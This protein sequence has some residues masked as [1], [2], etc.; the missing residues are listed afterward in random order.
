MI[1]PHNTILIA[2][3]NAAII[4][5]DERLLTHVMAPVGTQWKMCSQRLLVGTLVQMGILLTNTHLLTATL[6]SLLLP[7]RL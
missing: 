6:K 4:P 1:I 2:V 7:L 5:L 3:V